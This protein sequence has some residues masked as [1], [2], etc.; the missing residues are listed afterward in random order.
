MKL[1]RWIIPMSYLVSVTVKYYNILRVYY[2]LLH[3]VQLQ[4]NGKRCR[5]GS[6]LG[7]LSRPEVSGTDDYTKRHPHG[8]ESLGPQSRHCK[9]LGQACRLL[10]QST[11]RINGI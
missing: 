7:V 1:L 3:Y 9:R 6:R 5:T 8:H 11:K 10:R 2:L 4:R